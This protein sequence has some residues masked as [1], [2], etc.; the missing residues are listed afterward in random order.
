MSKRDYYEILGV[1]RNATDAELKK[2]YAERGVIS[3]AEGA[4]YFTGDN[5]QLAIGQG[6]LSASP[7]QLAVGYST[8]ASHGTVLKPEIIK[9]IVRE[10]P[11]FKTNIP[12]LC[13]KCHREGGKAAV[14]YLGE[15][16]SI[17]EN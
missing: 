4:G 17:V 7:L 9:A 11:T 15:Q 12:A 16:H 3:E 2:D 1:A 10:S 8:I 5:V 13:A 6:L 14:R